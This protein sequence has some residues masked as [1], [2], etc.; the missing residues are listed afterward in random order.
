M[1]LY[2]LFERLETGKIKLSSELPVSLHAAAQAPSKLELKPGQ[3]VDVETA[4][5]AI[6][7][8][9]ANDVAVVVAEAL[10][11]TEEEFAKLMTQKA[12]ALGMIHTSYHN[13]SGLPDEQQITT[14]RDQALLG[15]AIQ[16]RFPKYYQYF[17][18]RTF[19]F[20]GKS[21]RNHNHLLGAVTGVDGIKT[22]YI[23]ESG[24]NI[25]TSVRRAQSHSRARPTRS[26][27]IQ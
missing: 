15:R 10:G 7:T 26:S 9:S 23:R 21:M 3:T 22:G 27:L 1:T 25:V 14:A 11:G 20:R 6:V 17:S 24:F 2:L 8:K 12:H 4:I 16:D 5:R 19:T 13:A 18:T